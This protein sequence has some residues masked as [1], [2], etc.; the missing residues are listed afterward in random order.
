MGLLI[1]IFLCSLIALFTA[2]KIAKQLG[3][4]D[5]PNHRK[6]HEGMIPLVGGISLY[7]GMCLF[8]FFSPSANN[9]F[10]VYLGCSSLL[11]LVG[12]LDDK[13]D[14][15]VRIR[16]IFQSVAAISMMIAG[17]YLESLGLIVGDASNHLGWWGYPLTLL[18][19]WAAINA[20]NMVDGIDGLLGYLSCITFGALGFILLLNHQT[21]YATWSFSVIAA[22]LPYLLSN[23][24]FFGK[25]F[26][27]FMGDAGST[28]IGFTAVWLLLASSQG[29]EPAMRPVT[30]LWIIAIPL[31]DMVAIMYRRIRKRKSPFLADR[32]HIHHILLRSGF[33]AKQALLIIS[34]LATTFAVIGVLMEHV[35]LTPDWLM[36][37]LFLLSFFMYSYCVQHA[38]RVSR[39][40]RRLKAKKVT[41]VEKNK[42]CSR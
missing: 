22:I 32:Q 38:W 27:V 21:H 41:I 30:A 28:L 4:V 18:A 10:S 37:L 36:M 35:L 26:K 14:L 3:L 5:K 9:H 2:R 13:F 19:V 15:S 11:V 39:L 16:F 34:T 42:R 20:F 8:V 17:V 12:V 33:S 24:G 29:S 7:L 31:M 23:L 1:T 40:L 6:Q 25:K